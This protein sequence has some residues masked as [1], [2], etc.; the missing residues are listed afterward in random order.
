MFLEKKTAGKYFIFAKNFEIAGKGYFLFCTSK[1]NLDKNEN[2][3][4]LH[5]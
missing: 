1:M 5:I 4:E 3:E 2:N